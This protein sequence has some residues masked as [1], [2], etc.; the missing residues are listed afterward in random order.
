MNEREFKRLLSIHDTE[1][2]VPERP[3]YR[4]VEDAAHVYPERVAVVASDRTLTYS[5]LNAEA[6]AC[7]R[8]LREVG[9]TAETK[10]AVLAER[11]GWAYV[12]RTAPLKAGAAFM[13]ID[14][15]YPEER[16]RYILEDSGCRI[17]LTTSSVAERRADLLRALSDLELTV[18]EV[19]QA[20]ATHDV[21]DLGLDV[22]PH[23][24]AYVI[25]TSGSTGRPKGVMLE[26]HN[27]VNFC[28]VNPKNTEAVIFTEDRNVCLALAALTFDVSVMEQFLP[29]SCG[30]T[31]VLATMDEIMDPDAL[32]KLIEANHVDTFTCTPSYLSNMIEVPVFARA[33]EQVRV[34]AVGAEAF[35]ADLY[36]RLLAINPAMRIMNSY[37]PTECTVT[38]TVAVLEGADDITIGAPLANYHCITVSEDGEPLPLGTQGEL[39][40]LGEGVGRGYIGRDDLNARN[41]IRIFGIPAYRSGDLAVVRTDGLIEFHGRID[42]QVK[43]RGLRVELGE[44]E[45]VIAGFDGITQAVVTVAKGAQEY[46][47]AHFIAVR[48]IDVAE[49]RAHATKYLASYMV[50]Q[51]LMQLDEFPLTA[52][53]KVDKRALP[54]AAPD[55]SDVVPPETEVQRRL[56]EIASSILGTDRVGIT[57]DLLEA[58]LSSLGAIRLVSEVRSEFGVAIKT[59]QLAEC[60]SIEDLERLIASAEETVDHELREAYPLSQTQTGILVEVLRHPGTTMYNLPMLY[61]LDDSVDARRMAEAVRRAI[62]V[63]PYLFM[64]VSRDDEG[65]VHAMRRDGCP[66]EVSVI[67]RAAL[68]SEGELVRPFDLMSGELCFRAEV[69]VTGEG[70][71]LFF[72][73]HHI[74][75]DGGSIDV[76]MADV[77]RAYQGEELEREAY[78]GFELALDEEAALATGRLDVA[79]AFFDE[80][81]GGCG[82]ETALPK[83]GDA[84]AGH[85]AMERIL[86]QAD[87][88]AVRA[89][90]E[91]HN[92]TL[93]AFFTAAFAFTVKEYADA[94]APVFSTI[95]N[96]RSDPRLANSVSMLVKTLPVT[97][98]VRDDD[99]VVSLVE[100]CG[101][102]L[103]SAMSHDLYGFGE[104]HRAYGIDGN[105]MFA[106]QGEFEHGFILGGK[107]APVRMLGLSRARAELALDVSLDGD[108]VVFEPEYDPS[109]HSPYT[110]HGIVALMDHVVSEFVSKERLRDVTLVTEADEEAIR[111]L[112]D[113]DVDVAE[114]P[115]VWYFMNRRD[116]TY[117]DGPFPGAL[118]QDWLKCMPFVRRCFEIRQEDLPGRGGNGAFSWGL[119]ITPK[120]A[121]EFGLDS[122]E[123]VLR[124]PPCRCVHSVFKSAGR[125]WFSREHLRY[126]TDYAAENGLTICGNAF[127]ALLFSV[128]E[129]GGETDYF[130]VWIPVE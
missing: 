15:D 4:L 40:I 56:V 46:L 100:A 127:G 33:M 43:L 31:V 66:F 104:I 87:G 84:R 1:W 74:V 94:E 61:A 63:H 116:L 113:S 67:E 105:L 19:E 71:Y 120:Y 30:M 26:N 128:L 16:V 58:G 125:T 72:D 95:Y 13:P 65:V 24:L 34:V 10:V 23:D 2:P 91:A 45:R 49:L 3:A 96:G 20:V 29:L 114:R 79:K 5:E 41:F 110:V 54:V 6:N 90:C 115:E 126:I 14:P 89:F 11:D 8:A 97:L 52:N 119:A 38:S 88:G 57:T 93:N 37:G 108:V 51:S 82:G 36:T 118:T 77:E 69:Y 48:K 17:V 12:M 123:P 64:W 62:E 59:A 86:G 129:G 7:A 81:F 42:D 39:T 106:F 99:Y 28:D 85:V 124:L 70:N 22:A 68:P 92:L 21:A 9:A 35:P 44:V 111:T 80:R 75:S 112:H 18:V 117:D 55:Y 32:A 107:L 102:Y 109:V 50:P 25:Y 101:R 60:P 47:Q 98:D 53:G 73:T 103:T 76:L 27:L 122:G 130:E 121:R 78:T 83:D